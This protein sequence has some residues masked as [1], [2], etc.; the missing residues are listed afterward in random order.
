MRASATESAHD[1]RAHDAASQANAV[2]GRPDHGLRWVRT[3]KREQ[4]RDNDQCRKKQELGK[5]AELGHF[6]N[7]TSNTI[8]LTTVRRPCAHQFRSAFRYVISAMQFCLNFVLAAPRRVLMCPRQQ[9]HRWPRHGCFSLSGRRA[10]KALDQITD[11]LIL[12]RH[13]S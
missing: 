11:W 8:R 1:E 2:D 4:R 6:H 12:L 13:F 7:N 9:L 5:I 3:A 10:L